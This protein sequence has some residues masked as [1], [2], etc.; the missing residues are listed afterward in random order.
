MQGA[1]FLGVVQIIV[2][3][4]AIMMLFLFVLMLV[5]VDPSD[6]LVETLR[7]QRLCG[8]ARSASASPSCSIARSVGR[9]VDRGRRRRARGR[10]RPTATSTAIAELLFTQYLFAVRGDHRAADHRGARRDGARAPRADE[11]EADP[12]ELVASALRR[13]RPQPLPGPGV[14]ARHN[15]VGT[16]ALLP[17]G[18]SRGRRSACRRAHRRRGRRR[19]PA[20]SA[21][22]PS[23]HETAARSTTRQ[24]AVITLAQLLLLLS[25]ILFTSARSACWCAAT[26]SSC[27]CASS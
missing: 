19:R 26:R 21:R 11:P 27:S 23:R 10:Q 25:A 2:Y 5:G 15:A 4:G 9:R 22:T 17:D 20:R 12:A 1:P 18:T 16:P 13:G 14:F 8:R 6:S 24:D 3:T 7:G